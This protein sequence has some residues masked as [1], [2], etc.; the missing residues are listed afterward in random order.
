[1]DSQCSLI[2]FQTARRQNARFLLLAASNPTVATQGPS[3]DVVLTK[4]PT[5]DLTTEDPT[6]PTVDE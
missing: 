2:S 5:K 3:N 1:M 4:A 6:D